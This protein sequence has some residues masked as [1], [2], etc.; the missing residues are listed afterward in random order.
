MGL[1]R[2]RRDD[3]NAL[4]IEAFCPAVVEESPAEDSRRKVQKLALFGRPPIILQT[5]IIVQRTERSFPIM[6]SFFQ[7]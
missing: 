7:P 5:A 2:A 1:P 6:S 4:G 3:L